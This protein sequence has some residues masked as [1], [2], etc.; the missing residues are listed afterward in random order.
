MFCGCWRSYAAAPPNT[1]VCPVCL[2]L[3][4][5][6]PVINRRAVEFT[7][8]TGLALNCEIPSSR[9]FDRKNYFYPD[10]MKGYQISQYDLPLVPAGLARGRGGRPERAG[11]ASRASTW[12]KTPRK[13]IHRVE[14]AGES[15]SLVDVNRA[16]VPLMEIVERAGHALAGGGAA[17]PDEAARDP[18]LPR[19]LHGQHG[20]GLVPLRRQRLAAPA[21][22]PASL[23]AKVEVKNMN[24]FRAV[25]RALEL[26]GRAPGR[27]AGRRRA[28]RAGDARLGR[29]ARRD[30]LPAHEGVRARLPLLPRAR[31]AAAG[32]VAASG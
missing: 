14:P 27:R 17:V 1:H 11:S 18:A 25:Y 30:G 28:H 29:G 6:L 4:G 20:R 7:I 32:R 21:G 13:L 31:P 19:R 15:Y 3:P 12:R 24:S 22:Q 26:R 16:G 2:G 23:G 8:M 5:A 10:L 9:K